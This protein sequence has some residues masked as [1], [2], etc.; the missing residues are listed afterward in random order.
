MAPVAI[1][2]ASQPEFDTARFVARYLEVLAWI[3]IASM[4]AA[5]LV[6][7]SLR[8]DI[9][10]IFL[11]WAAAALKRRSQ[12]ARRWVLAISGLSLASILYFVVRA[13]VVSVKGMSVSSSTV[14]IADDALWLTT[15]VALAAGVV[16]AVP[17]V[18]LMS[19]RARSQFAAGSGSRT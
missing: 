3:S 5:P 4:I 7:S 11:F 15:A 8:I 16:I 6:F 10:P 19:E 9:T 13:M 18:V 1:D 14:R 17:V 2:Y 12:T